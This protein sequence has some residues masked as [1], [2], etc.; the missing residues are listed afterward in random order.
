MED[1]NRMLQAMHDKLHD[2]YPLKRSILFMAGSSK[3]KWEDI[4]AG[5]LK[6][7][8]RGRRFKASHP[9]LELLLKAGNYPVG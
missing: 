1:L 2:K 3:A 4:A 7:G 5:G 6:Y 9:D 8:S